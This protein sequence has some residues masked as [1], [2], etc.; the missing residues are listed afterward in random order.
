[1]HMSD[2]VVAPAPHLTVTR[3]RVRGTRPLVL[4]RFL[5]LSQ[6]NARAARTSGGFIGGVLWVDGLTFWTVTLWQD[7]A[8]MRAY[9]CGLMHLGAMRHLHKHRDAYTDAAFAGG[10]SPTSQ[11]PTPLEAH[12][13]LAAQATFYDLPRPSADHTARRIRP[14]NVRGKQRLEPVQAVE[15]G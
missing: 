5:R 1:M 13:F 6:E 7:R 4:A 12:T 14:P 15:M 3:L 10:V 2:V 11:L 9:A 8:R